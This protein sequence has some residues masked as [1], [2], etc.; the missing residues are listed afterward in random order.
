MNSQPLT[1]ESL[2]FEG[3]IG[4]TISSPDSILKRPD[5][6]PG[7]EK[8]LILDGNTRSA[9]AA[10]RSLGRK[11]VHVVVADENKRN[12]A[13]A[14]RYCSESF[15]CPSPA[16]DLEGFLATVK[17]E[18][19]RREI[20]VILPMT[21]LSTSTVLRHREE[22]EFS[23]VPFAE[24]KAFDAVTDKWSLLKLA[25]QLHLSIP[26]T[27]FVTEISSLGDI[28]GRLKFPV[29]L[30]PHRSTILSHG[31]WIFTSVRYARS[32]GELKEIAARYE[33]FNQHPFLIQEY[34]PGQ[35][36]GVFVLCDHGKPV[37]FFAHRR[38][39]ERP[40]A[41]GVSVLSES[42]EPNPEARRM[43]Q[44]ILESVGWHGVAMVEFK[45]A[46][47]GT[48]YLMEVNGRFWGS[49]QLA[50]DA[51]ADFPW[52]LYQLAIG[53]NLGEVKPYVT[54]IKCRWLL[55]DLVSLW[56]VLT[57]NGSSPPLPFGKIQ[58]V[59]Q[60]FSFSGKTSRYEINRWDDLRPF[61]LEATQLIAA[62]GSG[63]V[64]RTVLTLS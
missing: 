60:F 7:L 46:A 63:L 21:E 24:L 11:G 35:A 58:S 29:V 64:H 25:Q 47:D 52:L 6:Q 30:K 13:E 37:V 14:S 8:V 36:Q 59:T 53:R 18:C 12:L 50:I 42:I 51:G 22:F 43:A 56:K 19:S 54:G 27:Q 20:G 32:A 31:R 49:L 23:K 9:L 26:K 17:R 28:C 15:T 33:Y 16:N 40:P 38:L 5:S 44:A 4:T 48:P 45:V 57:H 3:G 62:L 61:M 41:G 1:H 2:K 10:T 34:I 55:G 39:R